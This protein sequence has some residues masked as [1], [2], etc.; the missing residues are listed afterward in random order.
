GREWIVVVLLWLLIM[1]ALNVD[2]SQGAWWLQTL[3]FGVLLTLVLVWAI[4]RILPGSLTRS[5]ASRVSILFAAAALVRLSFDFGLGYE[6]DVSLYLS[7][8]WKMVHEGIQSAYI[9]SSGRLPSDNPPVLLYP[10]W[11]LGHVYQHF[12]SP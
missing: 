8:T 10:F 11:L 3:A 12:M 4:A 9:N 7:L 1:V 5:E 2:R 6:G